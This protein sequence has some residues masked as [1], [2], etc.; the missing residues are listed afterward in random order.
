VD[1]IAHLARVPRRPTR[2]D[3]LLAGGLAAWALADA[4]F[5]RGPGSTPARV[6]FAL[7]ISLPLIV[8]RRAALEVTVLLALSTLVWAL[9]ANRP[10]SGTMPFPSLLVATFSVAL[11]ARRT[12]LALAAGGLL[13]ACMAAALASGFNDSRLTVSDA[14]ILTFFV[15][16]AWTSGWLIRRRAVQAER[17]LV[18]SQELAEAAVAEERA[19]IARE[20]H[21]IVAHSVSIVAVQ[22]G[23]AEELLDEDPES[24]R[25]HLAVVRRTAREAMTE[26]RRALEVLREDDAPHA[27]QPG[28]ARLE[29]LVDDVRLAGLPVELVEDGARPE[30]PPGVDLVAFRIVQEALTNVRKHAGAVP[31]RVEVRYRGDA[32]E[33]EVVNAA[34]G[35]GAD[36]NGAAGHGLIGMRERARLFGGRLETGPR[37]DGGFRVFAR[38]PVGAR[39]A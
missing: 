1:P 27:P 8:R 28:L 31:T 26:M 11:Y 21:D 2:S 20:L 29:D 39:P 10:E 17:A 7:L 19:R 9:T 6:G 4:F 23:A 38:L 36:G 34:G 30:L 5:S 32:V 12:P 33:I 14:I 35:R 3:V 22:A 24:A 16:G 37:P 15:C 18:G 13:M 25:R